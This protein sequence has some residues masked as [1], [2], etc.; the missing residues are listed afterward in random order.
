MKL[1]NDYLKK[2]TS[3]RFV[4]LVFSFMSN[5]LF[6]CFGQLRLHHRKVKNAKKQEAITTFEDGL[7]EWPELLPVGGNAADPDQ[8][9][10]EVPGPEFAG[11]PVRLEPDGVPEQQVHR[12]KVTATGRPT[13]KILSHICLRNMTLSISFQAPAISMLLQLAWIWK[14]QSL[15]KR[16]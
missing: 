15:L 9:A 10:D 12:A 13:G 4:H 16:N 11:A 8:A 2:E 14:D 1:G 3:I 6:R 5:C 7:F